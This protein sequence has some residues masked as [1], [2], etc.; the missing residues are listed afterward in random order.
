MSVKL[1]RVAKDIDRI[2]F[3][4]KLKEIYK[5]LMIKIKNRKKKFFRNKRS[6]NVMEPVAD[7]LLM[8]CDHNNNEFLQYSF[9]DVAVRYLAIEEYYK[10]NSFGFE[11]YK[12][13][14]IQGGNY[15][16]ENKAEKYYRQIRKKNRTPVYGLIKE[17]HSVNQF[18]ELIESYEKNGYDESSMVMCDKNLLNMNGSHRVA[19]ALYR[20][21]EFINVEVHNEI[22]QRRF[23]LNWFW[24]NG[25]TRE[26]IKKI[27]E[28]MLQ[29]LEKSRERI[30]D[31]YCILFPPAKDYFDDITEDIAKIDQENIKVTGYQ[32]Y[33]KELY[34]FVGF[35]RGIYSFDSI[36][37]HNFERKLHYIL[38]ASDIERGSVTYR[39]VSLRIKDPLY[40]LKD[41][42]GMPESVATVRLKQVI[43]E[44]Y[45]VK[46]EKFV[47][48][49]VG[50]YTHDVIIHSTDNYLSN[51]GCRVLLDMNKDVSD[52]FECL[53]TF[54]YTV[55]ENSEDKLSS[56][57]PKNFY[58]GEDIDILVKEKDIDEIVRI[59]L[60]FCKEHFSQKWITIIEENSPYGK[61]VRV[62]LNDF[63]VIMFDYM[64]QI[65]GLKQEYIEECL[66]SS[67]K[68]SY[69]YLKKEDEIMVRLCKYENAS[70]KSWHADYIMNNCGDVEF[71]AGAFENA[72][73]MKKIF[74]KIKIRKQC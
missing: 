16:E 32:D 69:K 10:K 20:E 57:F 41:D 63:T 72:L 6:A 38:S 37:Q 17:N 48:H 66:K 60:E 43:R 4:G 25:F 52:L 12:R 36:S 50:D 54:E 47:K 14:H 34:D 18:K 31:Y 61:R 22:F 29:L 5:K 58:L 68:V 55:V 42:N 73:K 39:I 46:E 45:K 1:K 23:S 64:K 27:K 11:L 65:P 28:K 59:T 71:K 3:G 49:Y 2:I 40:R 44:R 53:E 67:H 35:I 70:E 51:N 19:L 26:E 24:E 30:G 13:M 9:W 21:Q 7:L 74:E 33:S 8:Q 56:E 62:K 15:G